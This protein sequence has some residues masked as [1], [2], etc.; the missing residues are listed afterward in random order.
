[1]TTPLTDAD[2][3]AIEARVTARSLPCGFGECTPDECGARA[4]Q[5]CKVG[6][7]AVTRCDQ[8]ARGRSTYCDHE[9]R[10]LPTGA[11]DDA[12]ALLAEVHRL[13]HQRDGR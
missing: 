1:V 10:P 9:W 4:T 2:L 3:A 12:R 13:R 8:H 7:C 5:R 11:E 6:D